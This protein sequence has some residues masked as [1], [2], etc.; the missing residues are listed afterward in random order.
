MDTSYV[1]IQ[2]D[3]GAEADI[4]K[5]IEKIPEV[6]E[7]RGTYGIYDIFC[8]IQTDDKTK[9]DEII[10]DQIRKVPRLRAT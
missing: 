3:L 5:E 4:I 7:V 2:C 1:L 10:T 6:K 9:L 8:K